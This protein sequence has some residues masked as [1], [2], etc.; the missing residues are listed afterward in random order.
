MEEKKAVKACPF[1]GEEILAVAIKCKHCGSDITV[2]P[3]VQGTVKATAKS[4]V[5][6]KIKNA[7]I[8]AIAGA[9]L[10]IIG[11]FLP[12]MSAGIV[13]VTGFE[14]I[15]DAVILLVLAAAFGLA[16]YASLSKKKNYGILIAICS[17]VCLIFLGLIY[18]QML[19]VAGGAVDIAS[20]FYISGI[21]AFIGLIGGVMLAQYREKKKPGDK[22]K[23]DEVVYPDTLI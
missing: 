20:G 21:G 1:C 13:S 19:D 16:G 10:L 22:K 23:D 6:Q 9:A 3:G 2:A 4:E 12:W 15:Q 7:S 5:D 18:I 8:T 17:L 11:L 14:K